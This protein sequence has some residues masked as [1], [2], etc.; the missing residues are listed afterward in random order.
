MTLTLSTP[1]EADICEFTLEFEPGQHEH[2]TDAFRHAD[3]SI[4]YIEH[5]DDPEF[6]NPRDGYDNIATLIQENNRCVDLNTDDAGLREAHEHW[7]D[8]G[9]GM[10]RRYLA[11]YRPDILHYESR[12]YAGDSYGWG[13][14]TKADWDKHMLPERPGGTD[15]KQMLDWLEYAPPQTPEEEFD[16]EVRLYGRWCDGEVYYAHHVHPDG[17]EEN[18]GGFLAMEPRAIAAEMTNSPIIDTLY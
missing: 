1:V 6:C 17:T 16:Q 9:E 3:G 4:T 8:R 14:V 5:D 10:M 12:W 13:Y 2:L 15:A 11:I 18:C 7:C